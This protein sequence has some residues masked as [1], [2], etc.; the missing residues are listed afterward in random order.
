MRKD[1]RQFI[2]GKGYKVEYS[3]VG[4]GEPVLVLHGGHSNCFEELG[5]SELVEQGYSVI[6][7]SRPGYG[8]T[9]RELGDSLNTACDV[10]IE[11]LDELRIHQVHVIA[12]SAAGP[13]GI[14]L[15]SRYPDR[16]KSLVLQSAVTKRWLTS[17]DKLYKSARI[18]FH[19]IIEKFVWALMRLMNKISPALLFNSMIPSFSSLPKEKVLPQIDVEDRRRFGKMIDLQRSGYGFLIDLAQTGSDMTSLLSAVHCPALIMHSI[20]DSSVPLE[21]ARHARLNIPNARLCEL[22]S[23]GHLIWL[24]AG[25]AEMYRMLFAFLTDNKKVNLS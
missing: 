2:N 10:Y 13:S 7:P 3:L 4:S 22:D 8:R 9:S 5:N 24:G 12:I 23:W 15:V 18:M 19:P 17:D 25:R 11:L 6:T 14:H 16:V 20:H 1:S 21:H